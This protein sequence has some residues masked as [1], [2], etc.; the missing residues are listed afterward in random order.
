MH[1]GPATTPSTLVWTVE[2]AGAVP[3]RT[4]AVDFVIPSLLNAPVSVA[5]VRARPVGD[6]G[7]VVGGEELDDDELEDELDDDD[8]DELD[9]EEPSFGDVS[10]DAGTVVATSTAEG[11]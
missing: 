11:R 3:F 6:A 7:T 5:A 2:L 8:E 1:P 4:G 9:D 10:P